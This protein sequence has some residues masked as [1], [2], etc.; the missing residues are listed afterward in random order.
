MMGSTPGRGDGDAGECLYEY[1]AKA[2]FSGEIAFTDI[3][4]LTWMRS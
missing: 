1:V 2:G 3:S 4:Y